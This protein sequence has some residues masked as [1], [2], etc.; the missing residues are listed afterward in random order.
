MRNLV[1]WL[2]IIVAG[3]FALS[4][5]YAQAQTAEGAAPGAQGVDSAWDH[6]S[7]DVLTGN[8]HLEIPLY[9]AHSADM[10]GWSVALSYD[11]KVWDSSDLNY[12]GQ[13]G[14]SWR[15][16]TGFGLAGYGWTINLGRVYSEKYTSGT[17]ETY[18]YFQGLSGD[19]H[20]L[21]RKASGS[22]C[23]AE[24]FWYAFD[25]SGI[26]AQSNP[27]DP[28]RSEEHTSELQSLAYL[29]CRLLLEKKKIK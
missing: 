13:T 15:H 28:T 29:V 14:Q 16:L 9:T 4:P 19:T 12:N 25:G 23:Q 21:F 26:R 7:V 17:S 3:S 8:V 1:A 20:R 22:P 2:T 27:S 11:S 6:E 24:P 5:L 10:F 18:Y